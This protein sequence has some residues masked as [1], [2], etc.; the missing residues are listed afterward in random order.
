VDFSLPE[1][2]LAL[3]REVAGVAEAVTA[4]LEIREESWVRGFSKDFSR[5]MGERGW[6]G[7]ALPREVGGHGRTPLERFIVTE[8]LIA[9]GAPVGAS[10][11]GDRQIGPTLAEYGTADQI[12]RFVPGIVQG[13]QSWC[14]GLSEPDAGSDLASVRTRAV[15]DGDEWVIEGG[16][17]WTSGAMD[18][19]F[20][21]VVARTNVDVP[22]HRGLSEIIVPL[23][24]A[25]V[26]VTP[27]LDMSGDRHFCEVVFDSVRVPYGNLVGERDGSWR[28]VMRQLEHERG[29]VDRL[30][31]NAALYHDALELADC[32]D[33]RIRR[34]VAAIEVGLRIGRL[35]VLREV[36][37]QA[38]A[39]FSAVAK[40]ACTELEQRIASFVASL[41]PDALLAGRRA[42]AVCYA[43]AYT[44]QGGTSEI[45]R[46]V[47]GDRLLGLPR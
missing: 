14:L 7:M 17:V 34:E 36:M 21:Y 35:L 37:G 18:S 22:A 10:W 38:P 3:Q 33:P 19:D 24:A 30:V 5:E 25:G 29:G 9:A 4:P 27:I 43:P 44:I 16:K 28:Q 47:I 13:T 31:S 1:E 12:E 32:A 26:S 8:T 40:I 20:V 23:D 15:Q 41:G 2:V 39:G 42:R 6:L 45:L 46:N 11:I